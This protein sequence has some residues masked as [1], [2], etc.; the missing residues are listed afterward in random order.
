MIKKFCDECGAPAMDTQSTLLF[1]DEGHTLNKERVR[2]Y[3]WTGRLEVR[4]EADPYGKD[5]DDIHI[6]MACL[7]KLIVKGLARFKVGF[8]DNQTKPVVKTKPSDRSCNTCV[9]HAL[10]SHEGRCKDCQDHSNFQ[11]RTMTESI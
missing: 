8:V 10:R 7:V 5:Y 3:N 1:N 2:K 9:G 4:A 11:P 6:C